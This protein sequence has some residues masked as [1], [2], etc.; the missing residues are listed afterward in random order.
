MKL[1]RKLLYIIPILMIIAILLMAGYS[2]A[3]FASN[4]ITG[5]SPIVINTQEVVNL[6]FSIDGGGGGTITAPPYNGQT[7]IRPEDLTGRMILNPLDADFAYMASFDVL[8]QITKRM[9]VIIEINS[10]EIKRDETVLNSLKGNEAVDDIDYSF[11]FFLTDG[12][13]VHTPYG[14]FEKANLPYNHE[15]GEGDFLGIMPKQDG[16]LPEKTSCELGLGRDDLTAPVNYVFTIVYAPEKL[17]WLMFF[18]GDDRYGSQTVG[19]VYTQEEW[20][21][22]INYTN[23]LYAGTKFQFGLTLESL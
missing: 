23:I 21:K 5:I 4:P 12:I 10:V 1:K 16:R 11:T 13:Y 6:S 19:S 9:R 3:W 22:R 17:F 2:F 15:T 20:A 7:A 8:L 14:T 18:D